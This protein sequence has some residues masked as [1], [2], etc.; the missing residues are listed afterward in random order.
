MSETQASL[1]STV[2]AAQDQSGLSYSES[3]PVLS[4]IVR[5]Y[6]RTAA[7]GPFT[8]NAAVDRISMLLGIDTAPYVTVETTVS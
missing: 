7:S 5:Y 6:C 8:W 1:E 2:T 3:P 4:P